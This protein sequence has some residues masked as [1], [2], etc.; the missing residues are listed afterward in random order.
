MNRNI[1]RAYVLIAVIAAAGCGTSPSRPPEVNQVPSFSESVP[2]EAEALWRKAEHEQKGGKLPSAIAIWERISQTYS[3]NAIAARALHRLGVV[4]LDQDQPDRALQYF[5]YLLYMY[6]KWS[7]TNQ[8]QLDRLRAFHR[9]GKKKQ[10]IKE[11]LPLWQASA[12]EPDVQAGIAGLTADVYRTEGDKEAAFEWLSAGFAVASTQELQKMLRPAASDL[13]KDLNESDV[14]KLYKKNPSDFMKVFLEFRTAQLDMQKGNTEGAQGDLRALLKQNPSHPVAPEIQAALRGTAPVAVE[15]G[16]PVNPNRVG[17]LIP[18][19]GPY[20]RY[21]R[22][23]LRGLGL[24]IEEWSRSHSGREISLVVRDSQTEPETFAKSF[25]ELARDEGV[26]GLI[27]P[28]GAQSAKALAPL[29]DKWGVPIL[30]LTQKDEETPESPFMMHIFIDNRG[31]ARSLVHYCREKLGFTR[32]ATL[33]PDDRYG[34]RLSKIFAEIVKEEEGNLL[35]SVAYKEK[36]TD[37]KDSIQKLMNVAKQ[38]IPPTGVETTPFEALFIPDQVQTVSLIAPQLPYNNV[39]GI[40]LLGTNLWGEAPLVQVGGAY[41][42]QAVF[43]TPY[44]PESDSPRIKA[45]REKYLSIYKSVPSY[46]EAQA[47]DAMML[48]LEAR[49]S[50]LRGSSVDRVSVLQNLLQVKNYEGVAGIYSFSSDGVLN[51]NY[52]IMQVANGQLVQVG[53]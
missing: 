46:L 38:N 16:S 22:M 39:V 1:V 10:V 17:C 7:G 47:Y 2:P 8:V 3:N 36:S 15:T 30:A 31:L 12:A 48:F 4:Y 9:G 5:D 28:L 42:E 32:F 27:G 20:E 21:G 40:T 41:V 24:A 53:N 52:Q 34:Q 14:R 49:N 13:M 26:L 19:N 37:F 50:S 23:I 33:Y 11:A 18:L 6:P 45:F 29:A 43:A 44:F 51:R 35:A 25:E